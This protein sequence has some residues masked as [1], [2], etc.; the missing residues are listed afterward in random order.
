MRWSPIYRVYPTGKQPRPI[1]RLDKLDTAQLVASLDSPSGWQRDMVQM[2]LVWHKDPAGGCRAGTDG[3]EEP[4]TPWR[5]CTRC[6]RWTA[7]AS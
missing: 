1:P 4:P 3:G 5:A 7:L 6:A 2:M